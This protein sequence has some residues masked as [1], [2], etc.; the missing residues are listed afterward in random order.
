MLFNVQTRMWLAVCLAQYQP[1][2]T[3]VTARSMSCAV[4]AHRYQCYGSQYVLRSTSPQIPVLRLAV[5]AVRYVLLWDVGPSRFILLPYGSSIVVLRG[6]F[7][8]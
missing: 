5:R 3:S 7:V 4:S 2:D 6:I 1:T 8:K